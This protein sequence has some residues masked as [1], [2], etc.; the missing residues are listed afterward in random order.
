MLVSYFAELHEFLKVVLFDLMSS[1]EVWQKKSSPDLGGGCAGQREG[2]GR[3]TL[4]N[5]AMDNPAG[6]VSKMSKVWILCK[7]YEQLLRWWTSVIFRALLWAQ[8]SNHPFLVKHSVPKAFSEGKGQLRQNIAV[9]PSSEVGGRSISK[10]SW[11]KF[12]RGK[13]DWS[14]VCK[15]P[16]IWWRNTSSAADL[17]DNWG[18]FLPVGEIFKYSAVDHVTNEEVRNCGSNLH[19]AKEKG[20]FY[21]RSML[22]QSDTIWPQADKQQ[23]ESFSV[24][25]LSKSGKD[26]CTL[27][28]HNWKILDWMDW[29]EWISLRLLRMVRVPVVLKTH[30]LFVWCLVAC[31]SILWS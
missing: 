23:N 13:N 19:I 1:R 26:T 4:P 11:F 31:K 9:T 29:L 10:E 28:W 18:L 5:V 2:A 8:P 22:E 30:I 14:K 12:F 25:D 20:A 17:A 27:S 7:K 15:C 16:T 24:L 3:G 6:L 21:T